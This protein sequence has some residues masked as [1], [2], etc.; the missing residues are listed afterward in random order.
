[1]APLTPSDREDFVKYQISL[2]EY[3][4]A[5]RKAKKKPKTKQRRYYE[6]NTK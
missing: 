1:M 2:E 3:F 5:K 6:N 4:Q